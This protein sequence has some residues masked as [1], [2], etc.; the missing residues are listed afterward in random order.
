VGIFDKKSKNSTPNLEAVRTFDCVYR[1]EAFPCPGERLN[2][3]KS[4]DVEVV[5]A[6]VDIPG[7][8][9]GVAEFVRSHTDEPR[10]RMVLACILSYVL[11]MMQMQMPRLE[12]ALQVEGAVDDTVAYFAGGGDSVEA[13]KSAFVAQPNGSLYWDFELVKIISLLAA[14][15]SRE[16]REDSG[17][18]FVGSWDLNAFS[19]PY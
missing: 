5:C 6:P 1:G 2:I 19:Y 3:M 14:T 4:F 18:A 11:T 17:W 8:W 10:K 16:A 13:V 15:A 12:A 9:I 7:T